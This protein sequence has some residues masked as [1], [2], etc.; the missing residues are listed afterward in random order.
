MTGEQCSSLEFI[1]DY[2]L[3][4]GLGSPQGL[5][6]SL[7]VIDTEDP[8]EETLS[9]V[10]VFHLPPQFKDFGRM[11]VLLEQGAYE[12]SPE[13]SLAP[14][15]P[16]PAQQIVVLDAKLASYYL[17]VSVGALLELKSC[18]ARKIRWD[19]WKSHVVVPRLPLDEMGPVAPWVSGCRLFFIRSRESSPDV[20]MQVYDFSVQG[21]AQY[22][23]KEGDE[24]FGGLRCLSPTPARARI[25]RDRLIVSRSGHDS[26]VFPRVSLTVF[27]SSGECD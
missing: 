17:A 13:E 22:L 5:P 4:A 7:A 25:P 18:G 20:Q 26:I 8:D 1:D 19:E 23:S 11:T 2:H 12:P 14:F 10:T 16:D 15:Y 9:A 6:P 24:S 21:R 3:L 27:Y